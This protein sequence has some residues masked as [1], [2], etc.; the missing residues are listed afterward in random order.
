MIAYFTKWMVNIV[1]HVWPCHSCKK[2]QALELLVCLII[3]IDNLDPYIYDQHLI[4]NIK[5]HDRGPAQLRLAWHHIDMEDKWDLR[6][7]FPFL[8]MI[9]GSR[10]TLCLHCN[11]DICSAWCSAS[12]LHPAEIRQN[13]NIYRFTAAIHQSGLRKKGLWDQ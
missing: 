1:T 9:L 11:R 5:L 13:V 7:T 12:W 10:S 4:L 3:K 8:D 6:L 2:C